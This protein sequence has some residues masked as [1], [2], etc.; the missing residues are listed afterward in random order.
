VSCKGLQLPCGPVCTGEGQA[1][2]ADGVFL[3]GSGFDKD[4]MRQL[5]DTSDLPPPGVCRM[6]SIPPTVLEV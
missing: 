5:H 1:P 4:Q 2:D 6:L 3:S